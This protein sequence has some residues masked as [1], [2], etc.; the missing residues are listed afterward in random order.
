VSVSQL[1]PQRTIAANA[2]AHAIQVLAASTSNASEIV[3]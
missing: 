3:C 2:S 1:S